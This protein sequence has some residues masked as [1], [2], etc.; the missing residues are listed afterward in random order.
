MRGAAR[1][2]SHG[3]MNGRYLLIGEQP[4]L[5]HVH[6]FVKMIANWLVL[7]MNYLP[8]RHVPAPFVDVQRHHCY[9]S[10]HEPL[11]PVDAL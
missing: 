6:S 7:T 5:F 3:Q 9:S 8:A 2:V 10:F 1:P 4:L 11:R